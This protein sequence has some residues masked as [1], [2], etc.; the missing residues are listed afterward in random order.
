MYFINLVCHLAILLFSATLSHGQTSVI[1]QKK[2]FWELC[3]IGV[4]FV[5]RKVQSKGLKC[6]KTRIDATIMA[7]IL[8]FSVTLSHGQTCVIY[9]KKAFWAL[10]NIGLTYAYRK[11][12]SKGRKSIKTHNLRRPSWIFQDGGFLRYFFKEKLHWHILHNI[13]KHKK[14]IVA[15]KETFYPLQV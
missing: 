6:V 10:Y 12:Q 9:Q 3:N 1:Y 4:T 13:I 2:A 5:Y 15:C 14:Q 11:L 8:L 7:A